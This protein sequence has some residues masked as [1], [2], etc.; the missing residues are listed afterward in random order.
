[1][2]KTSPPPPPG[3][4]QDIVAVVALLRKNKSFAMAASYDLNILHPALSTSDDVERMTQTQGIQAVL[5]CLESVRA[6][7][8]A[9][10]TLLES[11]TRVLCRCLALLPETVAPVVLRA[12]GVALVVRALRDGDENRPVQALQFLGMMAEAGYEDSIRAAQGGE[13]LVQLLMKEEDEVC[14]EAVL[15]LGKIARASLSCE[16]ILPVGL[17]LPRL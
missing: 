10:S 6:A 8:A 14:R 17:C 1:M 4:K 12:N 2:N 7:T 3:Q 13:L 15:A 9:E 16:A 5:A 11:A